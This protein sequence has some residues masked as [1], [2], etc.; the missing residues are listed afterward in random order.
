M[1]KGENDGHW[2]VP[3][4][5]MLGVCWVSVIKPCPTL[6]NLMDCSLPG[7]SVH[8]MFQARMD[9]HFFL[10]VLILAH[11]KVRRR[12]S[13]EVGQNQVSTYEMRLYF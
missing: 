13:G 5:C 11:I 7:S 10:Q 3:I 1:L 6:C 9:C 12:K 2:L 8:E 4:L